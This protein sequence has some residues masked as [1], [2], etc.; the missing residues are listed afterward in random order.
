[1]N[2]GA[3]RPFRSP[4]AILFDLDGT[5]IDSAPDIA[6]AVNELLAG[7]D[8]PP[9]SVDQVKAMIGGGVKK[10]V[11]RA[12]AASGAPLL[13]SA[14]EEANR[15]MAPIYRRHLTGLTKLMPGVREILT[16]F[17]LNGTAMGVATNKPQLAT[18]EILLHFH[19]T[20]YLGAIVGGDAVTHLK[21]APDALLLALDQLGVEPTDALM[22]G[23][24]SSDVGA[25]RAAG[26]PVVLLRGGYTQ[27]PVQELGAD[28]VCDSLLDL[29]SAMQRLRAAA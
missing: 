23:D 19:L 28:L 7:S 17:H 9:L 24:S 29:P 26:M 6:A 25:A 20:E 2:V 1:M 27:I 4:R 10:L 15:A 14:L 13:A 8:L 3:S 5:L 11:E 12:F 18:R 21:P 16:H 22:V